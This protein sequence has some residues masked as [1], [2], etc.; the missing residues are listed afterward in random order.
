MAN[1]ACIVTMKKRRKK[2][3]IVN[4]DRETKPSSAK[5]S[6]KKRKEKHAY[7]RNPFLF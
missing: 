5:D 2:E 7:T 1:V 3:D 6:A 4:V